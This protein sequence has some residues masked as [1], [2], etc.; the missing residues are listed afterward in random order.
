MWLYTLLPSGGTGL[1][2]RAKRGWSHTI[3]G[4]FPFSEGKGMTVSE[5]PRPRLYFRPEDVPALRER[6]ETDDT[7]RKA[8]SALM[9]DAETALAADLPTE[10][11][12]QDSHTGLLEAARTACEVIET[13]SFAHVIAG[14]G[15]FAERAVQAMAHFACFETWTAEQFRDFDPSWQSALETATFVQ[16][17]AAGIDWLGDALGDHDRRDI[18]ESVAR[19]GVE[20]LVRD[21]LSPRT[22]VHAL[23]SMG[24]NW[25]MWCVAAAGVGALALVDDDDRAE[26]WLKLAVEGLGEFFRYP[27]NVLQNKA[28]SFDPDGGFY[29]SLT[30]TDCTLRY[31]TYFMAALAHMFPEGLHGLRF[32][33]LHPE[34]DGMADFML[35]FSYPCTP[36]KDSEAIT[37]RLIPVN[38]GDHHHG[39]LFHGEVALF[40]AKATGDGR[41]RWY[42]DRSSDGVRGPYQM[43]FYDPGVLP[44]PPRDLPCSRALC[45]I[46]WAS[47]RD[48]WEDDATLLAAKC[49]DTWNHAHAD[50]GSFVVYAGGEPLLVD[51]GTCNYGRPEYKGYYTNAEAHNVV[52]IDGRGPA[53]EDIYRGSK[54]P[55][56]LYPVLDGPDARY[57]LADATG[58]FANLYRRFLRHFLWL[59]DVIVVYDDLLAH[60]AGRFEWL[61]HG[62]TPPEFNDGKL[63]V[64]GRNAR[65]EMNILFPEKLEAER[66]TGHPPSNPDGNL[67]YLVLR[68]ENASPDVKF[69]GVIRAGRTLP[70]ARVSARTGVEWIGATVEMRRWRWSIYCNLRADGRRMHQNSNIEM[71]HWATDAYLLAVRMGTPARFVLVGAS[72]LRTSDGEVLFDCLSKCNAV[73]TRSGSE[74]VS[75]VVVQCPPGSRVRIGSRERPNR[76][77]ANGSGIVPDAVDREGPS[78]VFEVPS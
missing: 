33:R 7:L 66:R 8:R 47:L 38:F 70:E 51:S 63:A 40:L 25:W 53:H 26:H 54:F 11:D 13:C 27:G 64:K 22:R 15:R 28:R 24:H 68:Q 20:P 6:F 49:G 5:G 59:D 46:G 16:G 4:A 62:E 37:R 34:L 44:R 73:M 43:L 75:D 14:D 48:S 71:D 55:G 77:V 29:E 41:Y 76:V 57:L 12:T 50:A 36:R 19:L 17:Y 58:P 3:T 2:G 42:F 35:H 61:F 72:Y 65:L 9:E 39:R 78:A 31:Y 18:C 23:D 21:W 52:L 67:E 60:E 56:K 10:T 32:D 30:Y 69:L 45:G 1:T 74:D